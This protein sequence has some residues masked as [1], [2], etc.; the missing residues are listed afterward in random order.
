MVDWPDE[1]AVIDKAAPL[2]VQFEGLRTKPY[3]CPAGVPTIGYGT[4]SYPNGRKVTLADP[5]IKAED[6][7]LYLEFS[8]GSKLNELKR[9]G[10]I[11]KSPSVNQ[12]AAI[13]D[14]AYNVGVG[15]HDGVKGDLADSTLLDKFNKGDN[16]GAADAF[17][18][19]DKARDPKTKALVALPGLTKR[20][21][22]ER[23]LFIGG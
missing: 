20:R 8:L 9:S 2:V 3:M 16:T 23:S 11:L 22:A 4:T 12:L 1:K 17:L 21:Q 5:E 18:Q 15:V 10:A 13:L 19:W 6:A 7:E 14:L